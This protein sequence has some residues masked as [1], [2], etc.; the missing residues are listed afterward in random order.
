MNYGHNYYKLSNRVYTTIRKSKKPYQKLGFIE[1]EYLT[2]HFRRKLKHHAIILRI[3]RVIL[4]DLPESILIMDCLFPQS[5]IDSRLKCYELFQSFY[6][7]EIDF[8]KQKFYLFLLMKINP[9]K[10]DSF[11]FQTFKKIRRDSQ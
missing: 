3:D 1:S 2:E 5:N 11:L 8:S 4:D 6:I 10:I 9:L 7:N